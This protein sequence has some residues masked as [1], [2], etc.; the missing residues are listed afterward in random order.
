LSPDEVFFSTM[1]K[2]LKQKR[3]G[4]STRKEGREEEAAYKSNKGNEPVKK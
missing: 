4:M 1:A 3:K 2:C